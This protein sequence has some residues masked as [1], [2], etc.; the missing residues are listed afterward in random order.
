M[1]NIRRYS[2]LAGPLLLALLLSNS[3]AGSVHARRHTPVAQKRPRLAVLIVIDQFRADYLMRFRGFF[4]GGIKSLLDQGAVFLNAYYDHAITQTAAGHAIVAT[5]YEPAK[6][7]IVANAWID[8]ATGRRRYAVED[9]SV[10]GVGA[11]GVSGR[12]P[13]LLRQTSLGD[14]LK[15]NDRSS[16]VVSVSRKD[17]AA[18]L[19]GGKKA[20]L[21]LWYDGHSGRFVT[22]TYY[23]AQLPAWVEAFDTQHP[24]AS[25]YRTWSKLLPAE[26]Y[27][28]AREDFFPAEG[29]SSRAMFPHPLPPPTQGGVSDYTAIVQTPFSDQEVLELATAAIDGEDLGADS[30]TDLLAI[31]LSATD[32]IGHAYGPLS[33]EIEDQ[34]V[35]L[36]RS[37]G[38]FFR[39]LDQRVGL[40][41]VVIALSADHGVLPMPEELLRRGFPARRVIRQEFQ[42]YLDQVSQQVNSRLGIRGRLFQATNVGLLLDK[43]APRKTGLSADSLAAALA[44]EVRKLPIVEEALT[45]ADLEKGGTNGHQF[46]KLYRNNF[47]PERMAD[48]FV[49]YKKYFLVNARQTGT[50]HGSPYDYDRHVPV[51]FFGK[52][53]KA[54]YIPDRISVVDLAPTLARL[55]GLAPPKDVDGRVIRKVFANPSGR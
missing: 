38:R 31:S 47:D 53:V 36:D 41:N 49:V 52:G 45:R 6:T 17:R 8:Y 1:R 9:P 54:G 16:K 29:D 13:V 21:A 11:P 28:A 23:V 7:G 4:A 22:S 19:L 30:H 51:I 14:W 50:S 44:A 20:D 40:K 26:A 18:I 12:S 34:I 2:A 24:T 42:G 39:F 48:V 32:A 25:F 55:M 3:S 35:R 5:G 15:A 43:S 10:K 27:F 33:Q 37:L 46:L